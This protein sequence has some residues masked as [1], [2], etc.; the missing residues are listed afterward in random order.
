MLAA[1]LGSLIIFVEIDG[2]SAA[3]QILGLLKKL[4]EK[5]TD[6]SGSFPKVYFILDLK[7]ET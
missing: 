3:E 7:Q 4:N 2:P 6:L 5:F 1:V